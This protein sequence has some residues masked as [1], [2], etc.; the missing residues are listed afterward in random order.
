MTP[1]PPQLARKLVR[2]ILG[3][4][5]S[6]AI[7]LAPYLGR[8]KVPG[9]V[10]LLSLMPDNIQDTAIPLSAALMG[11][12]AVVIQ[13]YGSERVTSVWLRKGFKRALVLA[14]LSFLVLIVV[15]TRVVVRV[16]Y[17]DGGQKSKTYLIGFFRPNN[18]PPCSFDDSDVD[19]IARIGLKESKIESYWGDT[20]IQI[21]KLALILPYL[22][23]MSSFGLLV[24]L[25]L[26]KDEEQS[27][28]H[29]ADRIRG[30]VAV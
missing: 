10:P 1:P 23:F 30:D 17:D 18:K 4:S 14:L 22:L 11:I 5:V 9:F 16:A 13:W 27:G 24:G 28:T 26:L 3:F 2:Y 8:L 21:A 6:F 29:P 20:Q 12:V 7:G 15:H 19:C 25:L